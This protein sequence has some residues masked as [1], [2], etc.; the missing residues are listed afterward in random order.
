M[1]ATPLQIYHRIPTSHQQEL[2]G[3]KVGAGWLA[4]RRG[5]QSEHKQCRSSPCSVRAW[6]LFVPHWVQFRCATCCAVLSPSLFQV[7]ANAISL[8]RKSQLNNERFLQVRRVYSDGGTPV[9]SHWLSTAPVSRPRIRQPIPW[10][11]LSVHFRSPS[12][13]RP[14]CVSASKL[15]YSLKCAQVCRILHR[16]L[17]PGK[18]ASQ[19]GALFVGVWNFGGNSQ[20]SQLWDCVELGGLKIDW[21]RFWPNQETFPVHWWEICA[22]L[23]RLSR[24]LGEHCGGQ[25]A[26]GA[27]ITLDC[28]NN[29][30]CRANDVLSQ[31]KQYECHDATHHSPSQLGSFMLDEQ[32]WTHGR[33]R[34]Q[35]CVE[36][37]RKSALW[38]GKLF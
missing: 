24:Q 1:H 3:S 7:C 32:I 5:W 15:G 19:G 10:S 29:Q 20:T 38:H 6:H 31:A 17:H 18:L 26:F 28:Q 22:L 27:H 16:L 11:W 23:S 30:I 4:E 12:L 35:H 36:Q 13:A 2:F 25:A 33:W 8:R 37:H 34:K 9:A 14:G 21:R